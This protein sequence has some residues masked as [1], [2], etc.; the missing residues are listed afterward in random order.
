MSASTIPVDL[1]NPGQVFAC[2]GFLEIARVLHGT[3]RGGFEERAFHLTTETGEDPFAAVLAFLRECEVVAL[4]P[5]GHGEPDTWVSSGNVPLRLAKSPT[6]PVAIPQSPATLVAELHSAR[7]TVRVDHWGDATQRDNVKFW[8]GAGGYPGA[9]LLRDA[10][11][12]ARP[13]LDDARTD[14]FAIHAPMSSSFRFDWRRDYVPIA[15]GFS[16][17]R[18]SHMVSQGYPL[19]EL[20]AAVGL[21]HARPLR[22]G[23]DKLSYRYGALMG[24]DRHPAMLRAALGCAPLPHPI[25]TFR[26]RMDWPGKAGQARCITDVV[27]ET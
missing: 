10:L 12:L 9:A 11:E 5:L 15:T 18:H 3:V 7:G 26:I 21:T 19:T 14:P 8:A 20:L 2:L 16:L 22:P 23:R 1:R 17:N 13:Q 25:R 27:E 6:Y 24:T 4:A